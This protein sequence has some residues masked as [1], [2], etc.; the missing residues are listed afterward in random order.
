MASGWYSNG[1]RV[2]TNGTTA[3]L[4]DTIKV[5]L[6]GDDNVYTLEPDDLFISSGA[7]TVGNAELTVTGYTGGFGG[8]QRKTLASPTITAQTATN[9]TEYDGADFTGGTTWSALGAGENIVAAVA[10][11]EITNDA[12]SVVLGF[13]DPADIPT[14]GSDVDLSFDA[15]GLGYI[16]V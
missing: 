3:Y 1:I 5:M 7:A 6:L 13:M 14:N 15:N 4:T 16:T 10:V 9:R 2:M 11:E 12:A 8:A